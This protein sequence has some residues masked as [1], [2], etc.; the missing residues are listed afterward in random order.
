MVC[1]YG[2]QSFAFQLDSL[3]EFELIHMNP[4]TPSSGNPIDLLDNVEAAKNINVK[5]PPELVCSIFHLLPFSD[6]KTALL[7]CRWLC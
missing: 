4:T 2:F 5:L 3:S 6:L 7:V 1:C